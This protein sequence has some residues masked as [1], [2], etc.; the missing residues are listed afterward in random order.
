MNF[1][2][3]IG[4]RFVWKFHANIGDLND[5]VTDLAMGDAGDKGIYIYLHGRP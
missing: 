3:T 5:G 4:S 1:T 2:A